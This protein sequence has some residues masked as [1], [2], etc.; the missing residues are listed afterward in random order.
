[1]S[2]NTPSNIFK[3]NRTSQKVKVALAL[4][5]A[6]TLLGLTAHSAQAGILF[7]YEAPGVQTTPVSST[8]IEYFN[9]A[10]A[11]GNFTSF[12]STAI[13]GTYDKGPILPPDMFGGSIAPAT[14]G[15]TGTNY[16]SVTGTNVTTLALDNSIAYFEMWWSAGDPNNKLGGWCNGLYRGFWG[17]QRQ[18]INAA[19]HT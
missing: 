10:P 5:T 2:I 1:M 4:S 9:S 17:T 18:P 13:G 11:L 8:T 3:I 16:L 7:T 12:N 14:S 19:N 15:N 6:A